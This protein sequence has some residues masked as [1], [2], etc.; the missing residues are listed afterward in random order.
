MQRKVGIPRGIWSYFQRGL[1]IGIHD[2]LKGIFIMLWIKQTLLALC[3]PV[4]SYYYNDSVTSI[5]LIACNL[6]SC[7]FIY[8]RRILAITF[9]LVMALPRETN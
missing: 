2:T 7:N 1:T 8:L 5:P 4:Q 9:P 6:K 3:R